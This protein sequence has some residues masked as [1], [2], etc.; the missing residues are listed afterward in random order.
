MPLRCPRILITCD[1][2][3]QHHMPHVRSQATLAMETGQVKQV[4]LR[5]SRRSACGRVYTVYHNNG[6]VQETLV[7]ARTRSIEVQYVAA[8]QDRW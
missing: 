4:R 3:L 1:Y 8:Q 6:S 2:A 7:A 5:P